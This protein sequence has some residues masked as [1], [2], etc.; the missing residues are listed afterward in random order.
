MQPIQDNQTYPLGSLQARQKRIRGIHLAL[1][2]D[3]IP[4]PPLEGLN[5][6]Q[7]TAL[8][9]ALEG[10]GLYITGAAG[11]CHLPS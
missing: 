2:D 10:H 1:N 4:E 7:L 9:L 11:M 5:D 6:E 3:L 8:Q